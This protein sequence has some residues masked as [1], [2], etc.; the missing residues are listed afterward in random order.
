[1][2]QEQAHF[3]MVFAIAKIATRRIVG[4]LWRCARLFVVS[5]CIALLYFAPP[6]KA[7]EPAEEF[8]K[9]LQE[10]G[11]DDLA[12]EYLDRLK[13]SPLASD[14]IKKRIPYLR[15][16]ALVEQAKRSAD[17]AERNWRPFK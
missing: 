2:S 4:T 8:V 15:G 17:P 14:A 16:V 12:I 11:M 3:S 6:T 1:M 13:T 7:V 9:G 10:R 5:V